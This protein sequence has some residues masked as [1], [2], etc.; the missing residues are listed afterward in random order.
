MKELVF[1]TNNPHKLEEARAVLRGVIEVISLADL[2]CYDDIPETANTLEGNALLKANYIK[3]KFKVNC[4]SDDTGL[5][6]EALNGAPGVYSARFA[7]EGKK[8][9]D[10]MNKVLTLMKGATNRKAQFRAVIV[11]IYNNL[12][13]TFEGKVSGTIT[14]EPR[15]QGGFGYDPIFVPDGW[16]KTFAQLSPKKKNRISHRGKA[17]VKLAN[18]LNLN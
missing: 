7:G 2:G 15:G 9:I 4:F 16:N 8:P 3:N 10:N 17:L 14:D 12:T 1:A 18:F 13:Y 5:E 6:I 11:L